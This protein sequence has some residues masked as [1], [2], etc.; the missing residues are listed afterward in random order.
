MAREVRL[1]A[2][3]MAEKWGRRLKGASPDIRVGVERVTESPMAA[4]AAKQDK[5][6]TNLTE[7]IRNGK[8]ARGLARVSLPDWKSSMIDLGIGRIAAG[9]DAAIPKVQA[10]AGQ[11]IDYENRLLTTID[12]MPDI[13]LEDSISRMVAW[14]RGMGDFV[15][16]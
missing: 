5:M 15:R 12:A 1:N 3:Q 4:A 13:T 8:W 14:I 9:V 10:F 7:S 16:V 11:L 6:L 2:A